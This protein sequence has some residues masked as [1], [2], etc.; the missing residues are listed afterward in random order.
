MSVVQ[1]AACVSDNIA[2]FTPA[3]MIFGLVFIQIGTEDASG[4]MERT[5][6]SRTSRTSAILGKRNSAMHNFG[7]ADSP[8][9]VP[10]VYHKFCFENDVGIVIIRM[11]RED[12]YAVIIS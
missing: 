5:F 4:E 11:V 9:S 10:C 12:Q 1:L 7:T 3:R 8:G 6:C 2:S